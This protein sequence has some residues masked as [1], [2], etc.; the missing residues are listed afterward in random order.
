MWPTAR[1]MYGK[2]SYW[3]PPTSSLDG[4]FCRHFMAL[5]YSNFW[6]VDS[7]LHS[8][9]IPGLLQRAWGTDSTRCLTAYM[10]AVMEV[11]MK[12][13][14]KSDFAASMK[15]LEVERLYGS[16]VI[17]QNVF[18]IESSHCG[19][20]G[21]SVIPITNQWVL[22]LVSRWKHFSSWTRVSLLKRTQFYGLS[23][24]KIHSTLQF[25]FGWQHE[26]EMQHTDQ[27]CDPLIHLG[28]QHAFF[29][30]PRPKIPKILEYNNLPNDSS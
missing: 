21:L 18:R 16:W 20:L 13:I 5:I 25:K 22:Y 4:R 7:F 3:L 15:T 8:R 28:V 29:L 17:D 11:T 12:R 24:E 27:E 19:L 6:G 30:K 2:S 26:G 14:I 23:L 9:R 10:R 1:C